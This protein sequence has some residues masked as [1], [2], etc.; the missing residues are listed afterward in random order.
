MAFMG[1]RRTLG[2]AEVREPGG[3]TSPCIGTHAGHALCCRPGPMN[4]TL[5]IIFFVQSASE[6]CYTYSVVEI[7]DH[8][9]GFRIGG[10]GNGP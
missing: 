8:R 7:Q 4:E 3:Q 1:P 6:I 5:V 9:F 2:E 10:S